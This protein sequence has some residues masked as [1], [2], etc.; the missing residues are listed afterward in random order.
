MIIREVPEPEMLMNGD[1]LDGMA[2]LKGMNLVMIYLNMINTKRELFCIWYW[3][4]EGWMELV[5]AF[6]R[7]P[8]IYCDYYHYYDVVKDAVRYMPMIEAVDWEKSK[9]DLK[10]LDWD[11][12]KEDLK[13]LELRKN[14]QNQLTEVAMFHGKKIGYKLVDG[15]RDETNAEPRGNPG[16]T[17]GKGAKNVG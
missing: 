12:N 1:L 5:R 16:V 8:E 14:N 13:D 17:L 11:K 7:L 2:E 9:Q 6:Q 4:E 15:K 10:K 3:S